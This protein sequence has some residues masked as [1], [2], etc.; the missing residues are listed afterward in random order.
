VKKLR[1]I[2][3]SVPERVYRRARV[4]AAERDTSVSEL[5]R[6]FLTRLSEDA[7]DFDRRTRLQDE[8]LASVRGF[9]AADRLTR[10]EVHDRLAI[11]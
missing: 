7:S 1:N 9:T 8:I 10:D 2:T 11:R 3:V 6:E 4:R 5:V